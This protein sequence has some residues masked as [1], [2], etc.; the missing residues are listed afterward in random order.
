MSVPQGLFP[1]SSAANGRPA[2]LGVR[3]KSPLAVNRPARALV[4]QGHADVRVSRRSAANRT[5][6]AGPAR[7]I[8]AWALAAVL[9]A[10]G[11]VP[12]DQATQRTTLEVPGADMAASV[13]AAV[14]AESPVPPASAA[15]P[16]LTGAGQRIYENTRLLVLQVRT[17]LKTQDSQAAVGSGFLVGEGGLLLTDYHVVS[18][19][20]LQPGRFRLVYAGIDGREGALELLAIDVVNDLA[21][22]RPADAAPLT[23]RGAVPLR[24]VDAPLPRGARIFALGNP[25]DVGFAVS[26]GNYNGFVERSFLPKLFFGGS[27]SSG[28]SGGPALDE[29]GQLIGVNVEVRRDGEQISFLVPAAAV[30]AL[31]ARGAGGEPITT[32]AWAEIARQLTAHQAKLTERFVALPWRS[33]GNPRYRIPVPREDFMRCWGSSVAQ[34][35]YGVQVERSNCEM[36]SRIFVSD[37]LQSG[38]ITVRHEV[39]DGTRI[40]ALRFAKRYSALFL[41]EFIGSDSRLMTAAQCVEN[42]VTQAGL[43]LKAVICL[44]A[45]KK[46]PGLFDLNVLVATLD[47]ATVG[48]QGRFDAYGV[49]LA[50]ARKLAAHYIDGF[51]WTPAHHASH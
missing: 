41:N 36:D 31:L 44:R 34:T 38:F 20:A 28:M 39:Y 15:A 7:W 48:V 46:L 27:L 17:L 29:Q 23:G 8:S 14:P 5:S 50:S 25:L 19:Y 45:Y 33:A 43:P 21:L 24:P 13:P 16:L 47:G 37:A 9:M 42:Q 1:V 18:Q 22:L 26:E 4:R 6:P 30:R 3:S 35:T 40:G 51:A 32:A 2:S 49:T 12:T 11:A 10:A